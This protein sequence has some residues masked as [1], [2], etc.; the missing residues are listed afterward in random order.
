MITASGLASTR[1]A[2][3]AFTATVLR[4]K[5]LLA[6]MAMLRFFSALSVPDSTA[7]PKPSS[8]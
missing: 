2:R 5:L 8:W 4:W 7:W 1:A 3:P 6:R